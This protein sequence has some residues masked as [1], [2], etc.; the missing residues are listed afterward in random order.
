MSI[1]PQ[2]STYIRFFQVLSDLEQEALITSKQK[3]LLK[4]NLTLKDP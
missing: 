2:L 3:Q 1:N 4:I